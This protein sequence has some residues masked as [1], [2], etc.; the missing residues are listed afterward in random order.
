MAKTNR[1]KFNAGRTKCYF[2]CKDGATIPKLGR[3]GLFDQLAEYRPCLLI[4]EIGTNDLDL[5]MADPAKLA[6]DPFSVGEALRS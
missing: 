6:R 1:Q 2:S 4:L 5:S 3:N